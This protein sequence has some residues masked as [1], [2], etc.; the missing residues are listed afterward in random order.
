MSWGGGNST[1]TN[2]D[3]Q[4]GDLPL[5]LTFNEPDNP[6]QSNIEVSTALTRY[7][8]LLSIG[9]RM[10]SPVVT[11]GGRGDAWLLTF[12]QQARDAH[13]RVDFLSVH[14]YDWGG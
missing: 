12:M 6:D 13:L 8:N 9:R 3:K 2:L 10:G 7:T 4:A 5:C 1:T 14:W 11:E